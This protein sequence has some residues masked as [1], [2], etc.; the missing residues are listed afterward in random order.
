MTHCLAAALASHL[1]PP[2]L[3]RD[4]RF[5]NDVLLG[6]DAAPHFPILLDTGSS[7]IVIARRGAFLQ[8]I[9][10]VDLRQVMPGTNDDSPFA[11]WMARVSVSAAAAAARML[12][13]V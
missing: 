1:P 11:K 2:P 12:I 13:V 5:G 9:L 3:T 4:L 6:G 8:P 10:C 7:C